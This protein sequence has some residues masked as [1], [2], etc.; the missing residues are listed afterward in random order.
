MPD[1]PATASILPWTRPYI[2]PGL[3]SLNTE[4]GPQNSKLYA[5]YWSLG[6][7]Q[8]LPRFA[9]KLH[10]GVEVAS[11]SGDRNTAS[12]GPRKGRQHGFLPTQKLNRRG[13]RGGAQVMAISHIAATFPFG[14]LLVG[15]NM[16]GSRTPKSPFDSV[17]AKF[18][19]AY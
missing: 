2:G 7:V 14:N 6:P 3:G 8:I 11:Y 15:H 17:P 12:M 19:G 4:N 10:G 9:I 1:L 5:L 16:V 18:P 13:Y